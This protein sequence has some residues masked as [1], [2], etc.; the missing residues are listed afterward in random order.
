MASSS[1]AVPA[2]PVMA[3]GAQDRRIAF[4][5]EKLRAKRRLKPII[6]GRSVV[7]ATVWFSAL[8]LVSQALERT[9]EVG[10]GSTQAAFLLASH[11][12]GT[13][14]VPRTEPIFSQQP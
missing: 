13:T 8:T 4:S 1:Y 12:T 6:T 2:F 7:A 9:A 11:F 3:D 14:T 10:D 5:S